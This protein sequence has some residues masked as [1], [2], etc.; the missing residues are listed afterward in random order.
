MATDLVLADTCAWIDFFNARPTPLAAALERLLLQ[1]EVFTCGIVQFELVQGVRSDREEKA[2][3]D[4]FRAVTHL[5]MTAS[6]WGKA[7]RL[8][9]RLRKQ[10]ATLPFSDILI[11]TLAQEHDLTILTVDRHFEQVDGVRTVGK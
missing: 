4:A 11:A 3:L 9:G 6:L 1:G 10:G 7:G 8:S 5:E 2:L